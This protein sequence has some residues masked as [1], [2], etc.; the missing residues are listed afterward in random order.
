[1]TYH[2]LVKK[3]SQSGFY[4]KA[5]NHI[6]SQRI[7]IFNTK[8]GGINDFKV[9]DQVPVSEDAQ[10]DVKLV[11]P[12]L[13]IPDCSTTGGVPSAPAPVKVSDGVVAQ[14]V[15]ADEKGFDVESLGKDGKLNW[16]CSVPAQ[17]KITLSLSWEVNNPARATIVGLS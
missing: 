16:V 17:G 3:I 9:I 10:I 7:T 1:V 5:A 12:S 4:N 14:W 11:S 6:F 13:V 2:P 15:G 8:A